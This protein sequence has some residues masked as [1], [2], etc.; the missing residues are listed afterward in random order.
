MVDMAP[1][2]ELNIG[3]IVTVDGMGSAIKCGQCKHCGKPEALHSSTKK[4]LF[5]SSHYARVGLSI[6]IGV[7][8]S[9]D[10]NNN[11]VRVVPIDEF[12]KR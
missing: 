11:T 8:E 2:Q 10:R 4:C 5:E 7:V 3:D 9:I 1:G 12:G 6:P